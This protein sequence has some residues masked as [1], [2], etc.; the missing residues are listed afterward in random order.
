VTIHYPVAFKDMIKIKGYV[1]TD[2]SAY[3]AHHNG[4]STEDDFIVERFREL[5]AIILPPT[6]MVEGG[7]TPIGYC[8]NV[9]GPFN[10]RNSSHYSGGSSGG[11]AVV[12]ALGIAPV[13]I[14]YDGTYERIHGYMMCIESPH[15]LEG[16]A[17]AFDGDTRS[18]C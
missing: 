3:Y 13:S 2:G 10:P 18:L 6:S 8:V 1:L 17:A 9:R 15:R 7:V 12:V 11:S 16:G 4:P 14:G 5:G